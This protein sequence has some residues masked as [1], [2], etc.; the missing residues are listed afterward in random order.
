MKFRKLPVEIDA[1]QWTGKDLFAM[2]TFIEGEKPNLKTQA[3]RHAWEQYAQ[4]VRD[5]G[6]QIHTLEGV[7]L[8]SIGDF[9]IK[10]V[11]GEFYPCKPDIFKLTYEK[12]K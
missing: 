12:V 1:L 9:V 2:M 11:S 10:G 4:I 3:D 6:L 7:M 5:K 8:A